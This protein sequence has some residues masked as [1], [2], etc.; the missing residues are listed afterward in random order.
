V[1]HDQ[2]DHGPSNGRAAGSGFMERDRR[3][4][5][6]AAAEPS[7]VDEVD[8]PVPASGSGPMDR[9]LGDTDL[10]AGL[11][12]EPEQL[13]ELALT[14][15][16]QRLGG[17]AVTW[18][19]ATQS[20]SSGEPVIF[21]GRTLGYLSCE[22]IDR[23][24]LK[25]CAD[26]LGHWLGLGRQMDQLRGE[27]LR[28]EL[29][30]VWNRRHFDRFLSQ[31]L[32]RAR[33]ERFRVTLMVYDIDNF[34]AYN[35]RHGHGAGD[36]ILRET[37]KLMASV[38][39]KHDVV[40]RIGGD[41]FAVIFWDGE[42]P[43]R[44]KC[45]H[46]QSVLKIAQ[47]FQR[48]VCDHRFPKLAQGPATLTISGGL[49]SYPWDGLDPQS[50]LERADEALLESKRQGKNCLTFGPGAMRSMNL[51]SASNPPIDSDSAEA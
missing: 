15:I 12:S 18:S 3:S 11:L 27:S 16:R 37:A 34:K 39:R 6:A 44:G 28:D 29:T 51:K 50:L 46:P 30:G 23:R 31:I 47:R 26:W 21:D 20:G 17:A 19:P 38:V 33:K 49:A 43:R 25:A 36:E 14:V 42:A 48:A 13:T 8:G 7:V 41:E 5:G 9:K 24:L 45:E 1:H 35:D 4:D 22:G 10:I 40:A 32:A 2:G